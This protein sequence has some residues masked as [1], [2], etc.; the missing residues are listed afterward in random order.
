MFLMQ[1]NKTQGH[2]L[3]IFLQRGPKTQK[4]TP[5]LSLTTSPCI[6]LKHV[7]PPFYP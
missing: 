1:T 5:L 6:A 4:N 7:H 2:I 3:T